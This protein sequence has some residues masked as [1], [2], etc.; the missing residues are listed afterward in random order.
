MITGQA[1]CIPST[2]LWVLNR[3]GF[4]VVGGVCTKDLSGVPAPK[5][6]HR[7]RSRL[8]VV[9]WLNSQIKYCPFVSDWQTLAYQQS[10][11]HIDG[12]IQFFFYFFNFR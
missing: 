3:K 6:K 11:L 2:S 5:H 4:N 7:K 12:V 1:E 10:L 9:A 8:Q